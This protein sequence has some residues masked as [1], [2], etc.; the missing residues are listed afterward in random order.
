MSER[1]RAYTTRTIE[2]TGKMKGDTNDV[3]IAAP[4]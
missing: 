1:R 3:L 4:L 2:M